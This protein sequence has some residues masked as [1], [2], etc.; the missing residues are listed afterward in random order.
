MKNIQQEVLNGNINPYDL[1][2]LYDFIFKP[3]DKEDIE[4]FGF[5][6]VGNNGF[7]KLSSDTEDFYTLDI[8]DNSIEIVYEKSTGEN[9]STAFTLFRGKIKNKSELKKLLKMLNIK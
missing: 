3:L 9:L 4:S 1:L 2:E 6:D 5:L 7:Q 8:D